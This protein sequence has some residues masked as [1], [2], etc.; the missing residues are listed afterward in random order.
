MAL[1]VILAAGPLGCVSVEKRDVEQ[2]RD[3]LAVCEAEHGIDHPE[4]DEL[5]LR[6][7]DAQERYEQKARERWV[8]DPT[9]E[10]CPTPR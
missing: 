2:A 7:K 10:Q 1:P 6:K 5:R 9:R 4:C 3:A 8:C